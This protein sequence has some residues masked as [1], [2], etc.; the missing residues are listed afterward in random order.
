MKKWFV[1]SLLVMLCV[2]VSPVSAKPKKENVKEIMSVASLAAASNEPQAKSSGGPEENLPANITQLTHFGER[3]SWSPNGR[4]IAFMEKS[5]GDVF[6]IDL[7]TKQIRLLTHY[8]HA[9]YLRAQYLPNGDLLLVGAPTFENIYKTRLENQEMWVVK[10]DGRSKAVP[11]GHKISEDVAISR[12]SMKVAWANTS[13]NYP[14]LLEPGE[15][16]VYIAD[17]VYEDGVPKIVNKREVLR[18]RWP[19]CVAEVQD[20]RNNDNELIYT[21]YRKGNANILADI[22]GVD[23]NTGKVTTYRKVPDE[24]NEAE[25]IF[26]DGRYILVESSKDQPNPQGSKTID[27]WKLRLEPNSKSFKRLTRWGDYPGYKASNPVVSPDGR[28][29]AFQS[30]RSEDEP[31][32]GHGIFLMELENLKK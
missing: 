13:R 23:L 17:I 10:P 15:S 18:A 7:E 8:P 30:A 16:V 29:I 1:C 4:K 28:K 22:F 21:C 32:V 6:E 9:G 3:P 31:G 27:I 14:D 25:G 24:Y 19:E 5:F 20:F 12:E 2:I 11:L 26:P